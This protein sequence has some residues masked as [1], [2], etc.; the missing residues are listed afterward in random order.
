MEFSWDPRKDASNQRNHG[1][2][3]REAATVFGDL[4]STTFEDHDH[5]AIEQRFLTIGVSASGRV[6]V[7]AHT[8]EDNDIRIISA[9]R[10]TR[11]EL[12]FYEEASK[13]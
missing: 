1:V 8:E 3:F 7:V 11:R 2:A 12:K 4:V 5:S 6:L 10:V 9:R 13:A